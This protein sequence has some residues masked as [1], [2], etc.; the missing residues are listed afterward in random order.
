[1]S[2]IID[3]IM[4]DIITLYKKNQSGNFVKLHFGYNTILD[5]LQKSKLPDSEKKA[6]FHQVAEILYQNGFLLEKQNEEERN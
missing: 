3:I 1:M 5:K 4:S 6:C 2:T